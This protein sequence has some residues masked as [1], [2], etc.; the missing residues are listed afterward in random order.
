MKRTSIRTLVAPG[1]AALALGLSLT[2]C[3]AGNENNG[4]ASG[5]SSSGGTSFSGTLNGAG[6]TAQQSAQGVWTA[7][8]QSAH[9]GVT[10]NYDAVGSG[11]G[12]DQFL[13]GSVPFAGSDSYLQADQ[14]A[15][16]KKVCGGKE[17]FDLPDYVSPIAIAFH[18]KGVTKL[19]LSPNTAAGIFAGKITK[20]NDPAIKADNPGAKL[21][22]TT[23]TPVHRSDDS[24]T[25][26][27]FTDYLHQAAPTVWTNDHS[28]TWPY[29]SGEGGDGTSGVIAAIQAG[30]G[31]IGYA[32]YSQVGSL[33]AAS[34][35]VGSGWVA[36]TAD[37]AAKAL[38][39]SKPVPG[40]SAGD[41]AMAI[42]RTTTVSGAYPILLVSYL[43]ACPT[44]TD[45][46]TAAL[47]KAYLSYIVSVAGQNAAAAQV[48]SAPMPRA[49][50]S[51]VASQIA[52]IAKG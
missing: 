16:S 28:Q 2:A 34:V 7:A 9:S 46:N 51:N 8:F 15:A 33:S 22:G 19:N 23:I 4:T 35:K 18:L 50:Q 30:N 31:T 6:S 42:N 52:A 24:G 45:A 38:A 14:L 3:A 5:A 36:P 39:D 17:A 27:N 40:R 25:T 21:P 48:H 10:I 41:L 13:S 20:W 26:D 49:L 47:V 12:Q 29:K 43:I 1:A 32:D 44:Y 37:A 11:A